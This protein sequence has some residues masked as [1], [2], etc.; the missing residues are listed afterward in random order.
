MKR[1]I[2]ERWFFFLCLGACL[3][4]RFLPCR[5]WENRSLETSIRGSIPRRCITASELLLVALSLSLFPSGKQTPRSE[6]EG[7]HGQ[8]HWGIV[9]VHPGYV[10]FNSPV[11][12][13]RYCTSFS[14][15]CTH[16]VGTNL[17]HP[18]PCRYPGYVE[19]DSDDNELWYYKIHLCTDWLCSTMP[20]WIFV[21]NTCCF[22]REVGMPVSTPTPR[23]KVKHEVQPA[24]CGKLC[25]S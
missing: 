2:V 23:G 17:S 5:A 24:G 4:L 7:I 3:W 19:I 21:L 9:H 25:V 12:N 14:F 11:E 10:R 8:L 20:C 16:Q 6:R 1:Q 18:F 22:M 13:K 15:G